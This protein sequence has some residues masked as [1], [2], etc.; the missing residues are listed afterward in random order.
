MSSRAGGQVGE[1]DA[2]FGDVL[3]QDAEISVGNLWHAVAETPVAIVG[4]PLVSLSGGQVVG[5]EA[6]SRFPRFPDWTPDGIFRLAAERGVGLE[7]EEKAIRQA[8]THLGQIRRRDAFLTVNASPSAAASDSIHTL[9]QGSLAE[10][11]VLEITEQ[12]EVDSYIGLNRSLLKLRL[13]GLRVAIDDIGTGFANWGH[14]VHLQPD[15]IKLDGA[16]TAEID[17]DPVRRAMVRALIAFAR[18]ID[19]IV[20]AEHVETVGQLNAMRELGVDL[21][22]GFFLCRPEPFDRLLFR[23]AQL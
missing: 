5:Y 7:L 14:M 1:G 19:A 6:L 13:D 10:A 22:Q 16:W 4:Q 21:A 20:V 18:D 12:T 8:M 9:V 11:I 2:K 17:S 15:M 3:A 23:P